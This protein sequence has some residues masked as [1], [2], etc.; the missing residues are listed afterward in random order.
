MSLSV[1]NA[2]APA[3]EMPATGRGGAQRF[4]SFRVRYSD[5]NVATSV[6]HA[7]LFGDKRWGT[8][9]AYG[10]ADGSIS[11][12]VLY[13]LTMHVAYG[14]RH[15][16]IQL[17]DVA[18]LDAGESCPG[19]AGL[20]G[21]LRAGCTVLLVGKELPPADRDRLI[22]QNRCRVVLTTRPETFAAVEGL[23]I[24]DL[25]QIDNLVLPKEL[26]WL[27]P[28]PLPD[29]TAIKVP[30]QRAGD[31]TAAEFGTWRGLRNRDLVGYLRG[32]KAS[33]H[34]TEM[35]NIPFHDALVRLVRSKS[36]ANTI[37]GG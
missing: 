21:A 16:G 19:L 15:I 1:S 17:S 26:D 32:E 13:G 34:A 18:Y 9:E 23:D 6:G 11:F 30:D 28:R 4:R 2:P 33:L 14:L 37:S 3:A 25:S 31:G 22:E 27:M 35:A 10:D 20:L 8:N 29:Q 12:A 24:F 36:S 7:C 5:V